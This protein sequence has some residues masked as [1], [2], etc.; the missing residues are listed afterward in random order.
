MSEAAELYRL[1]PDVD[2]VRRANVLLLV[3][4]SSGASVR[5]SP[6]AEPL[7]PM[8]AQGTTQAALAATLQQRHPLAQDVG[9]KLQV[10]LQPLVRSGVVATRESA[11]RRRR[12]WA[13]F[14]LFRPDPLAHWLAQRV[15]ALPQVLRRA[16]LGLL[17]AMPVAGLLLLV[18]SGRLP[19]ASALVNAFAPGG[20]LLFAL[21]LVPLHEASHALACRMAGVAVGGGGILLHGGIM[22]GPYIETTQAYRVA[23]RWPRFLIPAVGPLVNL[24]GAGAAAWLLWLGV[25]PQALLTTFFLLCVLFVYLD[26]NPF[27]PT[28]GA[29]MLE[30]LLDDELARRQA[31]VIKRLREAD[32]RSALIY[33]RVCVLHLATAALLLY[34][35]LR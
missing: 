29:R 26:T 20:L 18:A 14:E 34:L 32:R 12:G 8:L 10:F 13:K 9:A 31:W 21:L 3:S 15:L 33:R 23:G 25:G 7:L 17:L 1:M 4:R 22:P 28:D 5:V 30:A 35:W 27:G 6:A 16:S 2:I 24:L 11:V 19:P